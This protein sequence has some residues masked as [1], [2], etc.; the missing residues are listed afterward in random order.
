AMA[1]EA[2]LRLVDEHQM[3]VEVGSAAAL[4]VVGKSLVHQ[5]VPDLDAHSHIVVV[6]SG[7]A[8]I[9]F[10]K[11]EAC[12]QRFPFPAPIIAKSGQEIF[13][14]MSDSNSTPTSAP[15]V[16][17]TSAISTSTTAAAATLA[18]GRN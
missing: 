1:A 17:Q 10:E 7:G 14:R 9:S 2:C 4:S 8:N 18:V 15:A 5:I 6:V 16:R 12:R 3:L 11:L 13:M